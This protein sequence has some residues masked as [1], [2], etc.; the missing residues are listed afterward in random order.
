MHKSAGGLKRRMK[1]LKAQVPPVIAKSESF[2][3]KCY[4]CG[5]VGNGGRSEEPPNGVTLRDIFKNVKI[6]FLTFMLGYQLDCYGYRHP[7]CRWGSR[8]VSMQRFKLKHVSL[9]QYQT[10]NK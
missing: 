2:H 1:I 5:K 10:Y 6:L 9:C 8:S 4:E 3:L 7:A